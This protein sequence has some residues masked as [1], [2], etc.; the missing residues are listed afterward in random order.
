MIIG[1]GEI[2]VIKDTEELEKGLLTEGVEISG[3]EVN[4]YIIVNAILT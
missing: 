1:R 4:V 3:Y 2:I